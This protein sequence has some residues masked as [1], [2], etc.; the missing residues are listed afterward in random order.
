LKT[1]PFLKVGSLRARAQRVKHMSQ[2]VFIFSFDVFSELNG[3]TVCFKMGNVQDSQTSPDANSRNVAGSPPDRPSRPAPPL[4]GG[5]PMYPSIGTEGGDHD[6]EIL[7][8][9]GYPT[10]PAPRPPPPVP[11]QNSATAT[12]VSTVNN[13]DGVPFVIN[14]KF[15]NSSTADRVSPE[16]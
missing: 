10:R 1:L 15:L 16:G 3:V 9:P 12:T 4:A 2:I 5:G 7:K 14:P 13:L 8:P 11:R 6:Y